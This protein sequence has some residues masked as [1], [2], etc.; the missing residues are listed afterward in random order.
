ML[1][2]LPAPKPETPK[3]TGRTQTLM[4]TR[5]GVRRRMTRHSAMR[6]CPAGRRGAG[7]GRPDIDPDADV[8]ADVESGC[9][10][11]D[12]KPGA[13]TGDIHL[14]IPH[15]ELKRRVTHSKKM[16]ARPYH[17]CATYHIPSQVHT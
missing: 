3:Q 2:V 13:G 11:P 17:L 7:G 12:T 4:K 16:A 9:L 5:H 6:R 14:N 1:F 8:E 10:V 15:P